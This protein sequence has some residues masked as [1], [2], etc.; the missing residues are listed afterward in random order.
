MNAR[1]SGYF[2]N[3]M[4]EID[5]KLHE[6][7]KFTSLLEKLE[8]KTGVKR[9]YISLGVAVFLALYLVVGYGA[10]LICN[11]VGFVYPA[12]AS[13]HAIETHDKEDD[14]KW[15]T[16]WVVFAAFSI[17]EF[18]SDIVLDWFPFYWLLKCVFLMWCFAPMGSN[19]SHFIY[20]SFI[21]PIF[22]KH[23]EKI[24]NYID[25]AVSKAAGLADATLKKATKVAAEDMLKEE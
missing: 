24:D 11:S 13:I 6:E 9:L 12:Y 7:N 25:S 23:K 8:Q 10:E 18:F 14:T 1:S 5:A 16:Y 2:N 19:G 20:Y 22:L 3:C 15:L 4:Q 17:L 21:R